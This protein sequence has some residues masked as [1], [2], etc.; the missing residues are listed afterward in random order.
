MDRCCSLANE[1]AVANRCSCAGNCGRADIGDGDD[2]AVVC[3]T[4]H[5]AIRASDPWATP[6]ELRVR[7]S[8][9]AGRSWQHDQGSI[10]PNRNAI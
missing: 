4:W 3:P 10:Q 7:L 1:W 2:L 5:R 6:E 9:E 8:R